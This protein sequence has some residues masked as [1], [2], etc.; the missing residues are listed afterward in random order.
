M[1]VLARRLYFPIII[2]LEAQGHLTPI[3]VI[4]SARNSNKSKI[5][6]LSLLP[7]RLAKIGSKLKALAWIH[8][9]PHHKSVGASVGMGT[10]VLKEFAPNQ[11]SRISPIPLMAHIKSDQDWP[12]DLSDSII[13]LLKI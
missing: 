1:N 8:R 10:T 3:G 12:T 2:F 9:F 4:R 11:K 7:A 13:S 5:L 6:C